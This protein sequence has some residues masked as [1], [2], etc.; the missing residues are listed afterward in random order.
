MTTLNS[1]QVPSQILGRLLWWPHYM[2]YTVVLRLI[3]TVIYFPVMPEDRPYHLSLSRL[4]KESDDLLYYV[5]IFF[6]C[7]TVSGIFIIEAL[8]N[9]SL[10][11][12]ITS[13]LLE[14]RHQIIIWIQISERQEA[15]KQCNFY[16]QNPK[17][18]GAEDH[19]ILVHAASP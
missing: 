7:T 17:R 13:S 1:S 6:C 19:P 11:I 10:E 5:F 16:F 12:K 9:C 2:R 8:S 4:W 3:H 18:H 14:F 15:Q